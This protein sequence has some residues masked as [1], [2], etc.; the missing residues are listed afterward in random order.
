ME[1][2][3]VPLFDDDVFKLLIRF[4][5]NVFFLAIIVKFAIYPSQRERV[6]AALDQRTETISA[7][8]RRFR[9][10][11]RWMYDFIKLREETGD[12]A[13]RPHDGGPVPKVTPRQREKIKERSGQKSDATPDEL[14][15]YCRTS[16]SITTVFRVLQKEQITRKKRV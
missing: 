6:A 14:R 16:A 5:I 3:K 2:L 15:R 9:V 4:A 11:R 10:S 8:A 12:I 13:P 7:I 1:L